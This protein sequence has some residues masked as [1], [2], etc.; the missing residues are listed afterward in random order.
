MEFLRKHWARL[1]MALLFLL[2]GVATI[3]LY[4]ASF[5]D[6]ADASN[7]MV[8]WAPFVAAV[9][10]FFGMALVAVLKICAPKFVGFAYGIIGAVITVLFT[11]ILA[12]ED[13]EGEFQVNVYWMYV[14]PLIVFGIQPLVRGLI[15]FIEREYPAAAAEAPKAEATKPAAAKKA[16][17]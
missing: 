1:S 7:K 6:L 4:W 12:V 14:V 10:F 15:K 5:A 2:G 9:L 11:V 3:A 13:F 17:K 8:A 16:A